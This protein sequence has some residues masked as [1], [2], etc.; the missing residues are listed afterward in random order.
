MFLEQ[1]RGMSSY[2]MN[3]IRLLCSGFNKG[4]GSKSAQGLYP[5]GSKSN[6]SRVKSA[7][8]EREV[9]EE[10]PDATIRL[11]DTVFQKWFI[12]EWM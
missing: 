9:I 4:F 12:K 2:Q 11:S 5:L 6:I 10:L 1:I 8:M 3:F 7:L